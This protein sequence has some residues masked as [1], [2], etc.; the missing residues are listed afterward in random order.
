MVR[1][2]ATLDNFWDRGQT[3]YHFWFDAGT[4]LTEDNSCI[5]TISVIA[6][7]VGSTLNACSA[8][9]TTN[10]TV[11]SPASKVVENS[12]SNDNCSATSSFPVIN[13]E[14][15]NCI[16][17]FDSKTTIISG[18]VEECILIDNEDFSYIIN[19]RIEEITYSID[20]SSSAAFAYSLI[21]ETLNCIDAYGS[22][23]YSVAFAAEQGLLIDDCLGQS[24]FYAK[25]IETSRVIDI[26]ENS[27]KIL[28]YVSETL[29]DGGGKLKR[30]DGTQ[31]LSVNTMVV[32][33]NI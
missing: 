31:W 8:T 15:G 11:I 25:T 12:T 23:L 18:L 4:S 14:Y 20:V 16:N 27:I 24:C 33:R 13:I 2:N 17:V 30:W 26:Y 6:V 22:F 19:S 29:R 9:D 7:M 32:F 28:A 3:W 10:A 21:S 5:D 1:L